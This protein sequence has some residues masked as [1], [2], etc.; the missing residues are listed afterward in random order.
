M[1][2]L[3]A[4][5]CGFL[6]IPGTRAEQAASSL[7]LTVRVSDLKDLSAEQWA[8]EAKDGDRAYRAA[9][10]GKPAILRIP[11]WWGDGLRPADGTR[12][13]IEL[14]YKDDLS[15]P[16]SA[17]C[18]GALGSYIGRSELHRFG[19]EA[20]GKWKVA[21]VPVSWD[22]IRVLKDTHTAELAIRAPA[23][24]PI[25]Q[26]VIRAAALP[27]DQARWEAE[28]RAWIRKVQSAKAEKAGHAGEDQKAAIP[29]AWKDKPFVPYARAYYDAVYPNSAP[30]GKEAGATVHVRMARNEFEPGAFGVYAQQDLDGVTYSV[31]SLTSPAGE[32]KCEIRCMTAEYDLLPNKDKGFVWTPQ[33]LWNAFPAVI[34]KNQSAWFY[35]SV[36]TLGEASLP[37]KYEGKITIKA[38]GAEAVLPLAVEVLPITLL[39]MDEAGLRMGG[40]V[41]GLASVGEMRTM[42]DHNHNA[43]NIWFAGVQPGMEK[44]DGKLVLDFT[45]LDEWM[46]QAKACGRKTMVWFL[47]GNPNG[48]PE[49]L[50]IERELYATMIGP[51]DEFM[52]TM[53]TPEQ[54][55]KIL[56]AVA[57]IYKDWL[58]QVSA[59][60]K[61]KEWP[62]IIFTPFDEPAKWS[63]AEP[64]A[65]GGRK[66][67]IG[68][69]P[70]IRD[71][72]KSACALMHEAAPENKVYVSMHRNYV[73]NVHGYNG[74]VG[75]IFIPDVDLVCTNAIEEDHELGDKVRKAGKLFWQYGGGASRRYG[76][77]F[78]FAAWDS[79][80]S[81][82][83]AYN[84]GKRF[85]V[86]EGSNWQYAWFSPFDTVL[87]PTYEE[88]REGWDDR[89]Y[90]ETAKAAAKKAGA[91]IAPL[92]EQI[93]KETIENRGQGGR[94]LVNDFWEEGREA[95]KMDYWRKLLADKMIELGK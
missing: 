34:K 84:W 27:E 69:G 30:K 75:E 4:F 39:S 23:D 41:T 63:Y 10:K 7:P 66:F 91:D 65:E 71:H 29:E 37:G 76:Y 21:Q 33:R 85:D 57:E 17:E 32:L 2:L 40:C 50:S 53:A 31:S 12:F 25:E 64:K 22:L 54:R 93:R 36:H 73:R 11:A 44:K 80:G 9:L 46:A 49:T 94:D 48:Y 14:T 38:G 13:I 43:I 86:T 89:R 35:L 67:A 92:I 15:A 51:K 77:G 45:Y 28:T 82:C 6:F 74:R 16:A 20:D 95:S 81:L 47:G 42:L 55:G 90:L 59:H 70:W 5:V 87:T 8:A 18:F 68:C 56:P 60:A 19:G 83:W 79:R 3:V 24:L 61:E 62:E 58:K 78:Y 72:F 52:K 88:L 1:R 26:L